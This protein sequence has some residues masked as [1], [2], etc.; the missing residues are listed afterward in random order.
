ML[1]AFWPVTSMK[2]FI[3]KAAVLKQFNNLRCQIVVRYIPN[4]MIY[5]ENSD[6]IP[7]ENFKSIFIDVPSFNKVRRKKPHLHQPNVPHRQS[8]SGCMYFVHTPNCKIPAKATNSFENVR[9]H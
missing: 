5:K 2:T 7:I 4:G 3:R 1:S 9:E 6:S 8:V